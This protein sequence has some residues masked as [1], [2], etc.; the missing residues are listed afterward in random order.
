MPPWV[1]YVYLLGGASAKPAK[2]MFMCIKRLFDHVA[3][4]TLVY[5]Y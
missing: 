3:S 5:V 1:A 4:H 2:A